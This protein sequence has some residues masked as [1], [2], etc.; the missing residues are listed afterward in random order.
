MTNADNYLW[1]FLLI[2]ISV[3]YPGEETDD[4]KCEITTDCDFN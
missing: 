3:P 1:V 2:G 4:G